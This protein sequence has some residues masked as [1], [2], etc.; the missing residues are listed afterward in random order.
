M[1]MFGVNIPHGMHIETIPNLGS[2]SCMQIYA[3]TY[4]ASGSMPCIGLCPCHC[5]V[6]SLCVDLDHVPINRH[7]PYL[8]PKLFGNNLN[9]VGESITNPPLAQ[10]LSC[11]HIY[12]RFRGQTPQPPYCFMVFFLLYGYNHIYI[13][14]VYIFNGSNICCNG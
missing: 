5:D 9:I 6:S 13:Y 14:M 1:P 3:S 11:W 4:L 10:W 7:G 8:H 2:S 12:G